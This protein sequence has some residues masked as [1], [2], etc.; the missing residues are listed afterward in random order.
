VKDGGA[1]DF[2]VGDGIVPVRTRGHR[3]SNDNRLWDQVE[4]QE[5]SDVLYD[6]SR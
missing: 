3:D 4:V 6:Q 5:P 2:E 1:Y